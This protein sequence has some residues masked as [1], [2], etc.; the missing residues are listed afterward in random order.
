MPLVRSASTS[1][2]RFAGSEACRSGNWRLIAS[3]VAITF[4]PGW[5][6]TLRMMAGRSSPLAP[7][8]APSRSFSAL[9]TTR[10]T[11]I[12]RTGAPFL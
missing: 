2:R 3:T 7:A 10:A 6:W 1:T 5:R 12:S 4:A 9:C 8:Q 11:S